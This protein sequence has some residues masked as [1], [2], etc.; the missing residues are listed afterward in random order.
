MAE[1]EGG[2]SGNCLSC[3]EANSANHVPLALRSPQTLSVLEQHHVTGV[4]LA[5]HD[6]RTPH[7]PAMHFRPPERFKVG[8]GHGLNSYLF[9]LSKATAFVCD[10]LSATLNKTACDLGL[11]KERLA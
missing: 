11:N 5:F 7:C 6:N 10:H 9:G 1:I 4:Y 2:R 3:L 8:S